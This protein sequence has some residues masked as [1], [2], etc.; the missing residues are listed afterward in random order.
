M[1]NGK[2]RE[3][4]QNQEEGR[5]HKNHT[6]P[7]AA[8]SSAPNKPEGNPPRQAGKPPKAEKP[9]IE[10]V[11]KAHNPRAKR[12]KSLEGRQ[13]TEPSDASKE[14]PSVGKINHVDNT[15]SHL[16]SLESQRGAAAAPQHQTTAAVRPGP[17]PKHSERSASFGNGKTAAPLPNSTTQTTSKSQ[18][19][20]SKVHGT[21][22]MDSHSK[23]LQRSGKAPQVKR[24]RPE[25]PLQP[26]SSDNQES[27]SESGQSRHS[28]LQSSETSPSVQGSQRSQGDEEGELLLS[29]Q[30]K[31]VANDYYGLLKVNS[32]ASADELS[33]ARR[34]RTRE[35]HPDHFANDEQQKQK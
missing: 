7:P 26:S 35:L 33:R 18:K 4:Q 27:P 20:S 30:V 16:E 5:G 32:N 24:S 25:P 10:R 21:S 28:S 1:S 23:E 6:P 31:A 11:G 8:S 2:Q 12:T 22:T 14:R 17:K 34:D 3:P 9:V 13:L 15:G 29:L 19:L